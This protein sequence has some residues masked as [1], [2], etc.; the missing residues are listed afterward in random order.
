M[1][2]VRNAIKLQCLDDYFARK[3]YEMYTDSQITIRYHWLKYKK[4]QQIARENA[5][6]QK[7]LRALEMLQNSMDGEL[8]EEEEKNH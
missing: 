1:L 5:M 2:Q 3:R 7:S 4:Q 6:L 8:A